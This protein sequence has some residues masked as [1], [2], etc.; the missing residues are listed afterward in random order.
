MHRYYFFLLTFILIFCQKAISADNDRIIHHRIKIS[1]ERESDIKDLASLGLA[2]ESGKYIPGVYIIGEFSEKEISR[3]K[4]AGFDYEILIEDMTRYYQQRNEK[5]DADSIM[6]SWYEREHD[7]RE[8]ETPENFSLGSMGGFHTY[9]EILDELDEM[10]DKFPHLI[11]EREPISD[12]LNSIEDRPVYWVRISNDPENLQD[13]P[14]V[15][16]TALM[17]AREPASMQ[18]MLF[19]MWYLLENYDSDPETQYLVDNLEMYFVP[20]INPDGYIYNETTNPNGGGM[21]RKNM[22]QHGY[23]PPGIDINRNYGYK[24]GYD[25]QGSSGDPSAETYR[26]TGPFSEPETKLQKIFAEELNFKLALNNHTFSDLLIYPWGYEDLLTPDSLKFINYAKLMTRENNY[27]YGTAYETLGYFCNGGSDDWFYGEQETKDKT[28]AFTPEAGSP[29]DGFWP[30]IHRIEEICAGHVGMNTYLARLALAYAEMNQTCDLHVKE[31]EASFDFNIQNF[32]QGSPASFEVFLEPLSD[33]II[34]TGEAASF[35]DMDVLEKSEGSVDFKLHPSTIK[36]EKIKFIA[37][38]DNGDFSWTDTI[39]KYFGEPEIVFYDPCEDMSNWNSN[40]WG[41]TNSV[42]FEPPSSIADSPEANYPASG[43]TTITTKQ[44]IDLTHESDIAMA[45]FYARWHIVQNY[46]YVQFMVSEDDGQTWTALEGNYTQRGSANL[47]RNEPSYEGFQDEWVREVIDLT[48]FI[49]KE[50]MLRFQLISDHTGWWP[51]P[52]STEEGFYFDEFSVFTID[53]PYIAEFDFPEEISFYQHETLTVDLQEYTEKTIE[54]DHKISWF[55]NE[56]L[57][58]DEDDGVL[59]ITIDDLTWSGKE[60]PLIM[61]EMEENSVI[62]G[63]LKVICKEIPKPVIVSQEELKFN[64]NTP[65]ILEMDYLHVEDQLFDY[66]EDF[67]MTIYEGN[68][69]DFDNQTIHPHEG[70]TGE[71]FV[72]VS[73]YNEYKE[74]EK[75]EVKIEIEDL[76]ALFPEY[77]DSFDFFYNSKKQGFILVLNDDSYD[78]E[79]LLIYDISGQLLIDYPVHKNQNKQFFPK[80]QSLEGVYIYRLVG[81]KIHSGKVI[82]F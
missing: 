26:G 35:T 50:I 34:E 29:S 76:T 45:E 67:D 22:R 55:D 77:K 41:I 66:P 3:I 62:K 54:D 56:N 24:W 70:Y 18:Q 68:N 82:A 53:M 44:T 52:P 61:V 13:K 64:M 42:Y 17:H 36:G 71:I 14:R 6:D 1:L 37:H 25:N 2:L 75:Y 19:Q 15:L 78:F 79:K 43:Q 8:Y 47:N 46:A 12:T 69:Y 11:S 38:L 59:Y 39:V 27:T 48:D 72:P 51:P 28:F 9:S 73:V 58:I 40:D 81:E 49:G 80:S 5:L 65:F 30:A 20:C 7:D 16:Y 23:T 63:S 21:H 74:S 4:E 31:H 57:I 33:N 32:G 10:A 60:N